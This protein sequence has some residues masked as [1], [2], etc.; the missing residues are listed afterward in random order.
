M[1]H[2]FRL[3]AFLLFIGAMPSSASAVQVAPGAISCGWFAVSET[4]RMA[5]C[6]VV[7]P[8]KFEVGTRIETQHPSSSSYL[9]L[10]QFFYCD[11]SGIYGGGKCIYGEPCPTGT[12]QVGRICQPPCPEGEERQGEICVKKKDPKCGPLENQ[13]L[14]L[15]SMGA[16]YG[17]ASL[18]DFTDK[19]GTPGTTCFPGGCEVTGNRSSCGSAAG[20]V[21]CVLDA[22]KF[23][24][25]SCS[26]TDDT[27]PQESK[28]EP[29]MCEGAINGVKVCHPCKEKIASQ[30]TAKKTEERHPNGTTKTTTTTKEKSTEMGPGGLHPSDGTGSGVPSGGGTPGNGTSRRIPPVSLPSHLGWDP[31]IPIDTTRETVKETDPATGK[32]RVTQTTTSS[33]VGA[34]GR[35]TSGVKRET[36]E[37]DPEGN[38]IGDKV[39][40]KQ[41]SKKEDKQDFCAEN[42]KHESCKESTFLGSCTSG[43][44]CDGDAIQCSIAKEQ[45]QRACALFDDKTS[46]EYILYTTEK[47]KTGKVTADLPGNKE[48]DVST[49]INS[50]DVFL[51]GGG[52]CPADPT[53][54]LHNGATFVIPYS[55]L[56]PYF[57]ILGNILVIISSVSAVL[58]LIRRI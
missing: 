8:N 51:G 36:W 47:E 33:Q 4:A 11:N 29:G 38:R 5:A 1:A 48:V 13:P 40:E 44:N 43:F 32:T 34:D 30:Q 35:V 15:P 3:I 16:S 31:D 23:T 26:E 25:N 2:L 54:T 19:V 7:P 56:C 41:E 14:G 53:I 42:P 50:T 39:V 37:E 22:P 28:C 18:G 49:I 55:S 24:G 6:L 45:H 57:V 10:T 52:S 46:P 27:K 21:T 58:I 12:E 17:K 9:P 20:E